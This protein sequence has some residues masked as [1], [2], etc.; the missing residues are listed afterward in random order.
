VLINNNIKNKCKSSAQNT[1]LGVKSDTDS[2]K[3][4][5]VIVVDSHTR[6]CARRI[7]LRKKWNI[8]KLVKENSHTNIIL[9][10]IPQRY[11][12]PEW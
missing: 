3:H 8:L 10:S 12:L 9:M 7:M 4:L 5:F 2:E 11:D 6:G 1:L